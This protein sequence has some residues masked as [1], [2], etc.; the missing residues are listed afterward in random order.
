MSAKLI[1]QPSK[2]PGPASYET[3]NMNNLIKAPVFS[4][5]NKSKSPSKIIQENNTYQPSPGLYE[6]QTSF[7]KSA[8]AMF[9]SS[10]R[11][12]LTET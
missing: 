10:N 2:V 6:S 4:M 9:G 3:N 8:G 5:G 1:R 11:K 12:N 7:N